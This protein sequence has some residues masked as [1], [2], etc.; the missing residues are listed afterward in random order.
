MKSGTNP[1]SFVKS[2]TKGLSLAQQYYSGDLEARHREAVSAGDVPWRI[3]RYQRIVDPEKVGYPIPRYSYVTP[4]TFE[5]H[6]RIL[7]KDCNL[8]SLE[9][10]IRAVLNKATLSPKT[11]AVTLDGGWADHFIHGLPALHNFGIP[12][13]ILLPTAFIGTSEFFW[14]DKALFILLAAKEAKLPLIPLPFFSA[15]IKAAMQSSSPDGVSSLPL[16]WLYISG[17]AKA[18]FDD[19]FAGLMTLGKVAEHIQAGYP[20]ENVFMSW[21]EVRTMERAGIRCGSLGHMHDFFPDFNLE[22]VKN[23]FRLSAETLKEELASPFPVFAFPDGV[24]SQPSIEALRDLEVKYALAADGCPPPDKQPEAPTLFR[25]VTM[26]ESR[27]ARA[28]T[29]L[30]SLWDLGE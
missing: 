12:A 4:E 16:I 2:A 23:E 26:F 6:L 24:V 7:K 22:T 14:Q 25:R 5:R 18:S 15:E 1:W 17:L 27:A 13:T 9:D 21:D 28:E 19:R 11:I 8:V 30:S 20:R 3:I 29:F 10:L